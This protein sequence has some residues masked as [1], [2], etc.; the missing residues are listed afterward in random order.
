MPSSPTRILIADDDRDV[1]EALKLLLRSE[2][3]AVETATSPA[4]VIAAVGT[5]DFAAL[6]MDMN[7][8]RDTTSGTEGLDLLAAGATTRCYAA[9][10]RHDRVG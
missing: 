4:G 10:C 9:D 2:G 8:T 6:L 1:L 7:Y 5:G 3:Y